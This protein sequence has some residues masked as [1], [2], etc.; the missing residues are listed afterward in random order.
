[1]GRS[2]L[3]DI[4]E[5]MRTVR[6]EVRGHWFPP[7]IGRCVTLDEDTPPESRLSDS[8]YPH[9][10]PPD[11]HLWSIQS[12]ACT[13]TQ[14]LFQMLIP[15]R[16][17]GGGRI[18]AIDRRNPSGAKRSRCVVVFLSLP[19]GWVVGAQAASDRCRRSGSEHR[20][21]CGGRWDN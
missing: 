5:T 4:K 18:D 20:A 13:R 21:T 7:Q 17:S 12:V 15:P 2:K 19:A 1:M 6:L 10:D 8:L 3:P 16:A 11:R 14:V 9:P